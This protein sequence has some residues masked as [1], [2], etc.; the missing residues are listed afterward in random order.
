MGDDVI[1]EVEVCSVCGTDVHIMEVPPGYIATPGTILGHELVGRVVSVGTDVKSLKPGQRVVVNPNNYCGV[2]RYC[3]AEPS[4][5]MREHHSD[6]NR[7]G[8]GAL[9]STYAC[10]S[11]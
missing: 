8:R 1:C 5:R 7:V 10:P 3:Q 9:P 11:G 6:G 4:Q 2:C